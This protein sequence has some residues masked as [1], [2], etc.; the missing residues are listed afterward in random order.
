MKLT[1][2]ESVISHITTRSAAGMLLAE[3]EAGYAIEIR[4]VG[5][6]E[7]LAINARKVPGLEDTLRQVISDCDDALTAIGVT[8]DAP[9]IPAPIS[10]AERDIEDAA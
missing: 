7:G 9:A 4:P 5:G 6:Q 2:L 1:D 3:I 10:D 8:P